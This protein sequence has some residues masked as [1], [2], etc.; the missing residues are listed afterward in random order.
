MSHFFYFRNN[1]EKDNEITKFRLNQNL[2]NNIKKNYSV[3]GF[4]INTIRGVVL[5]DKG[6]QPPPPAQAKSVYF[7][8]FF[9]APTVAE[10]PWNEKKIPDYAP[11]YNGDNISF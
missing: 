7:M 8:G 6:A 2:K 11:K 1:Y 4:Y 9:Q 3:V 5:G 10:P